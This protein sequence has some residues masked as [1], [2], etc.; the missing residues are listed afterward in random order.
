[1]TW[2]LPTLSGTTPA[3]S[4]ARIL[5]YFSPTSAFHLR[6]IPVMNYADITLEQREGTADAVVRRRQR[7]W[8]MLTIMASES[9]KPR[10]YL[11]TRPATSGSTRRQLS[12]PKDD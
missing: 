4:N 1:M 11:A 7:S 9:A 3:A 5:S 10:T 8:P 12:S 6:F 2:A